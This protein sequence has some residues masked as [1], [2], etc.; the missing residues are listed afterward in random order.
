MLIKLFL[1][2]LTLVAASGAKGAPAVTATEKA[3]A[4]VAGWCENNS[5]QEITVHWLGLLT[6]V[7]QE[8]Y[9]YERSGEPVVKVSA[10]YK[11]PLNISAITYQDSALGLVSYLPDNKK[12]VSGEIQAVGGF[13]LILLDADD[14]KPLSLDMGLLKT[15]SSGVKLDPKKH[16]LF[17]SLDL[18]KC[19]ENGVELPAYAVNASILLA[20]DPKSGAI[21][22]CVQK[23]NDDSVTGVFDCKSMKSQDVSRNLPAVPPGL[24]LSTV[25]SFAD[26]FPPERLASQLFQ[27]PSKGFL[28]VFALFNISVLAVLLVTWAKRSKNLAQTT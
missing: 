18:N 4:L 20:F 12:L 22:Q 7:R 1:L 16:T 13:P 11:L 9:Q 27:G 26:L 28:A 17:L 23:V 14:L 19:R 5:A 21:R 3:V 8:I 25:T 2:S 15:V 24:A 6:D 10:Q